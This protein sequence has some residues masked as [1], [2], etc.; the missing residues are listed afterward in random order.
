MTIVHHAGKAGIKPRIEAQYA[1]TRVQYARKNFSPVH[2]AAYVGAVGLRHA[3]RAAID[4]GD[5]L[6][7]QRK[8]AARHALRTMAGLEGPPYQPP[9]TTS[10]RIVGPAGRGSELQVHSTA[11]R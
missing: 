3:I 9:P 7:P 4:G 6:G 8:A 1:Y 2:R 11:A 10:V 5:G